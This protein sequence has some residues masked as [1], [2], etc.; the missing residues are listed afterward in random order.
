MKRFLSV[1]LSLS[2]VL[3][4]SSSAL[5]AEIHSSNIIGTIYWEETVDTPT[6]QNTNESESVTAVSSFTKNS[7]GSYTTYQY[8][9]G[10]LTDKHTT[11]PGSGIVYHTYYESDG[12]VLETVENVALDQGLLP[13][14]TSSRGVPTNVSIR[15]MGYMHY[16]HSWTGKYYS[17][18]VEIKD[19]YYGEEDTEFTFRQGTAKTLAEWTNTLLSVWAFTVNPMTIL[20]GIIGFLSAT[21][22]L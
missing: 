22:L 1:L 16:Y 6:M 17:I 8:I 20:S 2:L 14:N 11:I 15:D 7:D 12:S 3:G 10:T 19:E 5:A 18:F 21:G 13:A 4:I 9:D